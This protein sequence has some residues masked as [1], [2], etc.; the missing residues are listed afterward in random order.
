MWQS[1][2]RCPLVAKGS[3]VG[4]ETDFEDRNS[5]PATILFW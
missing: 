2:S 3:Y 4:R 1:V 5:V